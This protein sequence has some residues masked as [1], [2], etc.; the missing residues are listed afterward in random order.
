MQLITPPIFTAPQEALLTIQQLNREGLQELAE[1]CKRAF[2]LFWHNERATREEMAAA[3]G[4]NAGTAFAAH[5]AT[6]QFLLTQDASLLSPA[7]YTPPQAYILNQDG[8][9]TLL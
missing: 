7:D 2:A 5:A 6:V 8:T 1:K 9:I 4:P 3:I